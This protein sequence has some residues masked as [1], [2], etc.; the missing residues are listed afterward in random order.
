MPAT[1]RKTV[2]PP[3]CTA[4]IRRD[5]NGLWQFP[6]PREC[7]CDGCLQ[8]MA[9]EQETLEHRKTPDFGELRDYLMSAIT[10]AHGVPNELLE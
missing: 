6:N 2:D 9:W 1:E 3:H 7:G 5:E 10:R 8:W 4:P